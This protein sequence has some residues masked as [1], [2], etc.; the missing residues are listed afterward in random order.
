VPIGLINSSW[1]GTRIEP[2]TPVV[3]LESQESTRKLAEQFGNAGAKYQEQLKSF[4]PIAEAWAEGAREALAADKAILAFPT[5]PAK[6]NFNQGTPTG[7]YNGMI[8]PLVPLAF[9]G[10]IWYQGESNNGEGML[11]HDKMKALIEGWRT[12]FKNED[13]PFYFV[14]LAPYRYG[15]G[16][17][18][19]PYIWEAQVATMMAVKNTGMAVVTDI[20]NVQ[21]IHPRN[22]QGVGKRLALWA[23]AKTY[24][25]KELVYSGPLYKSMKVE[26]GG[27]IRLSFD[28]AEGGLKS[29]DDKPLSDFTIAGEDG[30]FV[31]AEAEI[32]GET[33]VVSSSTVTDPRHV[34]FGWH[35][36]INP[37]LCNQ[38]G[39]PASPFK[40]D[41]WM[42]GKR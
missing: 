19:L 42:K 8:H 18:T 25:K 7:L 5:P 17:Q 21:D 30:N 36:M 11:Y 41:N 22:K 1:G 9:R 40:T 34:R 28:H 15:N 35:H 31:K 33:V 16:E 32:D 26:A 39:L 27:K 13:M 38:T 12:V 20:G 10:S 2:W 37:N 4:V 24:G 29:R 6:P 23:L 14:Q 3:G